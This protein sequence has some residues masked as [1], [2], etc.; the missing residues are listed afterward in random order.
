[1]FI[2]QLLYVKCCFGTRDRVV[3]ATKLLPYGVYI[4]VGETENK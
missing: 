3:T 2:E 4:V 1:M